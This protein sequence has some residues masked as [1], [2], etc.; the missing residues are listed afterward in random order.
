MTKL[1]RSR[2]RRQGGNEGTL[3]DPRPW[4]AAAPGA[5]RRP[6]VQPAAT[7]PSCGAGARG[8]TDSARMDPVLKIAI[9]LAIVGFAAAYA[10]VFG[11]D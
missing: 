1:G 4:V 10:A 3:G 2:S 8:R 11:D 7:S 9:T 6:L 5:R